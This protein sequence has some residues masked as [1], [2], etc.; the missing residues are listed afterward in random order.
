MKGWADQAFQLACRRMADDE[1]NFTLETIFAY[2]SYFIWRGYN[3]L[4]RPER[5]EVN[6]RWEELFKRMSAHGIKKNV[7]GDKIT[8]AASIKAKLNILDTLFRYEFA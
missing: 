2:H 7:S 3:S 5:D 8:G 1:K 6:V 4:T